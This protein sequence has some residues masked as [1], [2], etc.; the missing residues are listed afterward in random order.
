MPRLK[1]LCLCSSLENSRMPKARKTKTRRAAKPLYHSAKISDYIFR[2]IL[3]HFVRDH[4]ATET[5]R[6]TRLSLNSVAAIFAKL[7]VYFTEAGLFSDP[8]KIG[9]FDDNE[10]FEMRFLEFHIGR[11]KEKRGLRSPLNGPDYHV[12]ESHWRLHYMMM[13]EGRGTDAVHA[14]MFSHLLEIILC[15]GPVGLAPIRRREGL[16]LAS[17]HFNHRLLWIER[18]A[19]G[20]KDQRLRRELQDIRKL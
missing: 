12:C 5:A 4:T 6:E 18:N 20:F 17:K 16:Q 3:W 14:M 11:V 1:N 10:E 2:K 15:C 7:R 19:V 13:M 9:M 8:V